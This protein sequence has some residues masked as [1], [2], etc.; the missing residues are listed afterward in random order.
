MHGQRA[1]INSVLI[2]LM[3]KKRDFLT[4]DF[5]RCHTLQYRVCV[6]VLRRVKS[7]EINNVQRISTK[8][9]CGGDANV[10]VETELKKNNRCLNNGGNEKRFTRFHLYPEKP[11][12]INGFLVKPG[13]SSLF[14]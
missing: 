12:K 8:G 14:F 10:L 11:V 3:F 9:R 4:S 6:C 1:L 2:R 5:R 13:L 7:D